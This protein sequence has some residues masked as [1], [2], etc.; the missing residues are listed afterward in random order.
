MPSSRKKINETKALQ[1][2]K[3]LIR[4]LKQNLELLDVSLTLANKVCV[5]K[6]KQESLSIAEALGSNIQKH[7]QL[8]HPNKSKDV[9]RTFRTVRIRLNEQ[10][11]ITLY[12]CFSDYMTNIIREI[13]EANNSNVLI[14][15]VAGNKDAFYGYHTIC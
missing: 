14:S 12:K 5:D 9:N 11:I 4:N 3:G 1:R 6:N 10:T 2:F 15:L 8:N 7:P 13:I